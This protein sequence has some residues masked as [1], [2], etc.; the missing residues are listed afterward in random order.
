MKFQGR[1]SQGKGA[2]A[3]R[4]TCQEAEESISARLDGEASGIAESD[5][6][7]HL[8]GCARCQQFQARAI[9]VCRRARL[10][11]ARPAPP[12]LSRSLAPL[13]RARSNSPLSALRQLVLG[14]R[15]PFGWSATAQWAAAALPL[16]AAVV[17]MFLGVGSHPHLVPSHPKSRCTE[18]VIAHD[19]IGTRP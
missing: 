1:H 12:E 18:W 10:R 3:P 5:L 8:A 7:A 2:S 16:A 9:A 19:S 4:A 13:L 6:A 17:A 14:R 11:P 15:A